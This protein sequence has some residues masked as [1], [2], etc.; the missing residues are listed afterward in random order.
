MLAVLRD[1]DVLLRVCDLNAGG[2]HGYEGQREL[3]DARR[4]RSRSPRWAPTPSSSWIRVRSRWT[5]RC[6][7]RGSGTLR[8]DL[9]PGRPAG[10]V[11]SRD[12]S[13]FVNYAFNTHGSLGSDAFG[14]AG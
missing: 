4:V 11:Y 8:L 3:V 12:T 14:E 7:P 9:G 13:G 5:S 2:V 1:D 10:I 6:R